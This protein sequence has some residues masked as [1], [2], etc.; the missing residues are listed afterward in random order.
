MKKLTAIVCLMLICALLFCGCTNNKVTPTPTPMV[1]NSP[2]V[3]SPAPTDEDADIL[4]NRDKG[5]I[6]ENESPNN[7]NIPEESPAVSPVA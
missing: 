4:P 5:V 1:T 2:E 7:E 3:V 6:D